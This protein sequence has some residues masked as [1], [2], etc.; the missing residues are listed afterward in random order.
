MSENEQM[1]RKISIHISDVMHKSWQFDNLE[2]LKSFLLHEKIFWAK[3]REGINN[4]HNLFTQNNNLDAALH[5]IENWSEKISNWT[6]QELQHEINNLN[7]NYLRQ[8]STH[9]LWSGH[10]FVPTWVETY[11]LSN[12][13]GAG[14]L[15]FIKD[16]Q[17]RNF[18]NLNFFKGY[19]LAYEFEMQDE[20]NIT[21][22]RTAEKASYNQLRNR[23]DDT[24]NKLIQEVDEFKNSYVEWHKNT[25]ATITNQIE[26]QAEAFEMTQ[27][28]RENEF[29]E[30][31]NESKE[32]INEL[33]K[34]YHEKLRLEKPAQYWNTKASEYKQYAE[35]W[36]KGLAGLL[37]G[38]VVLFAILFYFW[39]IRFEFGM[40][41]K[42]M[43]GAILFVT[44]ITIY[45]IAVQAV[46]KMVF[47]SYH[48]QRDAE[49]REQLAYVYLALTNEQ[50]HIDEESRKIVLQS[51]FS[52]A[53]TGLLK[54]SSPTMPGVGF[55]ELFKNINK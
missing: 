4:P 1:N 12:E 41:L 25:S 49:E 27:T 2:V 17:M 44:L 7:Q 15:E 45:A 28:D 20:T 51:L 16:K 38:G 35:K 3:S 47:S 10:A 55:T 13:I 21:K 42:S 29:I 48:L 18:Q 31:M 5:T 53:D 39:S 23:L 33:E 32:K 22:R 50:N 52:R 11:K 19:M 24:T 37:I 14:F 30:L 36:S 6:D 8:F 43:Q 46:S 26:M 54:D 40:E 34:T 9:W